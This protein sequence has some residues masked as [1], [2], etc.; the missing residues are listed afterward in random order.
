MTA[1]S[2][3][4]MLTAPNSKLTKVDLVVRKQFQPAT[5]SETTLTTV[6]ENAQ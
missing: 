6:T 3:K 5:S 1:A 4:R 2:Q